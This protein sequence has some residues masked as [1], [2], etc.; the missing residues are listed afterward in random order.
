MTNTV[1]AAAHTLSFDV[2]CLSSTR[3]SGSLGVIES[4]IRRA[5]VV[6]T[7][8]RV[9]APVVATH[10]NAFGHERRQDVFQGVQKNNIF[11]GG[12]GRG[13]THTCIAYSFLHM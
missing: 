3:L 2:F 13:G 7:P 5:P 11:S 12:G 6:A 8:E 10:S 9:R 4:H 1:F